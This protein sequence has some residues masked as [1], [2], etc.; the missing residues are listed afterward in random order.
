MKLA[1]VLTQLNEHE[2]LRANILYHKYLGVEEF[3]VFSDDPEDKTSA[4][5]MD[6]PGVTALI[7]VKP[8]NLSLEQRSHS[9]M[10]AI[11]TNREKFNTARQMLNV[12]FALERARDR[13]CDWLLSMDTD[14]FICPN[15]VHATAG[16]LTE[17]FEH[18][19]PEA[20]TLLFRPLEI[21]PSGRL[22][23]SIFQRDHIFLN[24]FIPEGNSFR[25]VRRI[26]RSFPDPI[27]GGQYSYLGY[28]GHMQARSAIRTTRDVMPN[29]VHYFKASS[30]AK[31]V[32]REMGWSLHFNCY[33]FADFIKKY[34]NFRTYPDRWLTGSPYP[35]Y[36]QGLF[37]E[38]VNCGNFS[39]D[40]LRD[41][42]EKYLVPTA[43]DI[44]DWNKEVP[45][46]IITVKAARQVFEKSTYI[47]N[48]MPLKET[49]I[50]L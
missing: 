22:S 35:W 7:S 34:R 20:D 33:S 21:L 40:Y 43:E 30:G 12:M 9:M 1:M 5:I 47:S 49:M 45:G 27:R 15:L 8:D 11:I 25:P 44:T 39:L 16:A 13:D 23:E 2:L 18:Q 29:S 28:I 41:Y 24:E 19:P 42:Y 17:L 50:V 4:T 10:A 31:L 26:K 14:E 38:M 6:I 36:M 37:R 46:S 3:F 48:R 32:Q